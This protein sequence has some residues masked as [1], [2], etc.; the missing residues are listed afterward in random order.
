MST[1]IPRIADMSERGQRIAG[2]YHDEGH[3]VGFA[4]GYAQGRAD[5]AEELAALQRSAVAVTRAVAQAGPYVDL[6]E[7]RGEPGRA[8]RQRRLL[9][10]RGIG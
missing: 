1:E 5:E 3:R 2:W 9:A 8:E 7:L 6:C 4:A 10:E